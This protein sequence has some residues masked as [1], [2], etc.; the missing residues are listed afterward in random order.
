MIAMK[1]LPLLSR[2]EFK[3]L[4]GIISDTTSEVNYKGICK[5][6][7]EGLIENHTPNEVIRGVLRT[8]KPG[9]SG[10][11]LTIKDDLTV[12]ELKCF[13]QS[14]LGEKSSTELFQDLMSA[15]QHKN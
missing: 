5:Q 3:I 6:I 1:Y 12:T 8:I 10:D 15:K 2:K 4:G 14:Y 9:N 7:N 11:M 13:L